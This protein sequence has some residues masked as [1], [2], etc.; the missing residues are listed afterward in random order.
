MRIAQAYIIASYGTVVRVESVEAMPRTA[1]GVTADGMGSGSYSDV[2]LRLPMPNSCSA[3][4]RGSA[5]LQG[6]QQAELVR[7]TQ[8]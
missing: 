8:E 2:P 7:L 5:R 1:R 6:A 4:R 3:L